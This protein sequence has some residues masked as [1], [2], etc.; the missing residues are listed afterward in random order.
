MIVLVACVI[1]F[2]GFREAFRET[3]DVKP[4]AV[5][6]EPEFDY[7]RAQGHLILRPEL[8]AGWIVTNVRIE[9][10]KPPTW[11]MAMFTAGEKFAGLHQEDERVTDLVASYVDENADEGDPVTI[12]GELAGEWRVFTDD[13]GDTGLVLQREDDVVLVYGSAPKKELV[14]LAESLTTDPVKN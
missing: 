8:P 12:G 10:T 5:E 9:P 7:R 3:P 2:V 6:W 1:A 11:D 14:A 4:Q 13:G